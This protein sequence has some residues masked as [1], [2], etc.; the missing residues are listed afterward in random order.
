MK[1]GQSYTV[2]RCF[3]EENGKHWFKAFYIRESI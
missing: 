2:V 1:Q 3:K